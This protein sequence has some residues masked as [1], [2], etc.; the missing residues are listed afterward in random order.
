MENIKEQLLK[1]E[2]VENY[3]APEI[4]KLNEA[5]NRPALLKKLPSRWHKNAKVI[6]CIGLAG[7]LTLTGCAN[8]IRSLYNEVETNNI[9]QEYK[10]ECVQKNGT[11]NVENKKVNRVVDLDK[12]VEEYEFDL[13]FRMHFG[14]GGGVGYVVHMTEQ[15]VIA[16]I[17]NLLE[18]AGLNFGAVPPDYIVKLFG[19]AEFPAITPKLFDENKGV[20]ISLINWEKNNMPFF[21]HGGGELAEHVTAMFANQTDDIA[22]GV[23]HIPGKSIH[24]E[25][26]RDDDWIDADMISEYL[27]D[28][29]IAQLR[30]FLK[31]RIT[32]QV[33]GFITFLQSEGILPTQEVVI[34]LNGVPVEFESIPVVWNNCVMVSLHT[35]SEALGM[36]VDWDDVRGRIELERGRV[37]MSFSAWSRHMM[38]VNREWVELDSPVV[39][40]NDKAL[41][42][43]IPIAEAIGATVDWDR[44][45]NTVNIIL[46]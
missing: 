5:R 27:S 45:A 36:N 24:G 10:Y 1:I 6:A 44:E 15:E 8:Y 7:T 19:D 32:V 43:L 31:D 9:S 42:P 3:N 12:P 40:N 38:S 39:V 22:F 14:G 17:R 46:N 18:T 35:L 16:I 29:E 30:P 28:E 11:D 26:L 21:S 20:A 2:P 34:M 4:P 41:V 37:S 13:I 23:F 25:S 33:Q